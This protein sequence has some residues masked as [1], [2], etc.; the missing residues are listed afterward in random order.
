MWLMDSTECPAIK[1]HAGN[2]VHT[3][4]SWVIYHV[5]QQNEVL[6]ELKEYAQAK[7]KPPDNN[8]VELTISY[9]EALNKIFKK[10]HIGKH[11]R[12]FNSNGSTIRRMG[13]GFKF[14]VDW[15]NKEE[16]KEKRHG[17]CM[18]A[19]QQM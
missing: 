15:A 10:G 7:D 2:N 19:H 18:W 5:F 16:D 8:A 4:T 13:E 1:S 12:V 11:V 6:A 3:T 14:F 17:R 9:L